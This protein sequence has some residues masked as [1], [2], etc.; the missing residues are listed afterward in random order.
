L[1]EAGIAT[2]DKTILTDQ[3]LDHLIYSIK[4]DHPNDGEVLNKGHLLSRGIKVTRETMWD[5]I[6]RVDY[7]NVDASP[8][9]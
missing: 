1:E 7:A 9:I 3:Q 6:H 8:C 5:S 2:D 4:Q